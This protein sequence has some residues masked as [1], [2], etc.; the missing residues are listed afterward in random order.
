MAKSKDQ[1]MQG[2]AQG[3]FLPGQNFPEYKSDHTSHSCSRIPHGPPCLRGNVH[4]PCCS[5]SPLSNFL[6]L[7][8]CIFPGPHPNGGVH[9][10]ERKVG[11]KFW[12]GQTTGGLRLSSKSCFRLAPHPAGP[13]TR[14]PRLFTKR[15]SRIL[16]MPWLTC[17]FVF[18]GSLA[19]FPIKILTDAKERN[20]SS[21]GS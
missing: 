6:C 2:Q 13:G 8:S 15:T 20:F 14:E 5:S 7:I 11:G 12:E 10:P 3:C 19:L 1:A 21:H 17:P 18:L 16:A 9:K 4:I